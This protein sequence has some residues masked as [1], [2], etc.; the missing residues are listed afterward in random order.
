M[1]KEDKYTQE[2]VKEFI[3]VLSIELRLGFVTEEQFRRSM[4]KLGNNATEIDSLV[5][6]AMKS[7]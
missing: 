6:E 1:N 4:A 5:N 2:E 7:T 3:D